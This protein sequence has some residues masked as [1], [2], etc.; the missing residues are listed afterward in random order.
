MVGATSTSTA[1]VVAEFEMSFNP[2]DFGPEDDL[3]PKSFVFDLQTPCPFADENSV[4]L[5]AFVKSIWSKTKNADEISH[6][7]LGPYINATQISGKD[8][9]G[10]FLTMD[11]SNLVVQKIVIGVIANVSA[12]KLDFT[13]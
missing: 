8:V 1:E 7:R 9:Y 12:D 6:L 3:S 5:V 11:V 4:P 13:P 2:V 10:I